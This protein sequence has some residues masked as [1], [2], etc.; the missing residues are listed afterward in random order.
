MQATLRRYNIFSIY[1]YSIDLEIA[2]LQ[3]LL[4]VFAKTKSKQQEEDG[5]TCFMV[6]KTEINQDSLIISKPHNLAGFR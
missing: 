4:L 5:I 1:S 6:D 3:Q 2:I